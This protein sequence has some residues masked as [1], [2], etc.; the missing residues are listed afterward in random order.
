MAK[1]V[2]VIIVGVITCIIAFIL[3]L[4]L[5]TVYYNKKRADKYNNFNEWIESKDDKIIKNIIWT[6]SIVIGFCGALPITNAGVNYYKAEYGQKE[7]VQKE[8]VK[9]V[10]QSKQEKKEEAKKEEK[11][12]VND[13][14]EAL[15]RAKVFFEAFLKGDA[16]LASSLCYNEKRIVDIDKDEYIA[17][18][19]HIIANAIEMNS[20]MTGVK[21]RV[22]SS[23]STPKKMD[24]NHYRVNWNF[25]LDNDSASIPNITL[26]KVDG[27]WFVDFES[28]AIPY[29]EIFS[30]GYR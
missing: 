9:Q 28:F 4:V 25:S 14:D 5:F 3:S 12:K 24:A 26:V 17:E 11:K 22:S 27:Q 13:A 18:S 15:K 30:G 20:K 7:I 21:T 16:A 6:I 1:A 8:P 10:A 19:C 2:V 29:N 23:V